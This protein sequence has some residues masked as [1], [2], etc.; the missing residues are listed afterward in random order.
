MYGY[1][2]HFSQNKIFYKINNGEFDNSN[3]SSARLR[4]SRAAMVQRR[5]EEGSWPSAGFGKSLDE[6]FDEFDKFWTLPLSVYL[7]KACKF[8]KLLFELSLGRDILI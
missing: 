3:N 5:C 1:V 2:F 8:S 6:C 7:E 4:A